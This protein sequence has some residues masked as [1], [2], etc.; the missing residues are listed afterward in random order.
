M[1]IGLINVT[2]SLILTT[3]IKLRFLRKDSIILIMAMGAIHCDTLNRKPLCH[4]RSNDFVISKK[5][6]VVCYIMHAW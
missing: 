3:E 6:A 1:T 4:T 5:A 2:Q